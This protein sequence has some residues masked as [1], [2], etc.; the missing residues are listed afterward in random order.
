MVSKALELAVGQG[1]T[2]ADLYDKGDETLLL[3][4]AERGPGSGEL[5]DGVRLRR[6]YKRAFAVTYDGVSEEIRDGSSIVIM[7]ISAE[8]ALER[9][10]AERA[11][12]LPHEVIVYAPAK[13]ALKEASILARLPGG[14]Q[15]LERSSAPGT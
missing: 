12:V 7:R 1:V 8:G 2:E 10:I 9:E 15:R 6:L 13:S 14:V 4:L 3:F 5:V 11:G